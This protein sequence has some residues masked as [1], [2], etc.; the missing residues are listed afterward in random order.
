MAFEKIMRPGAVLG[1]SG[2]SQQLAPQQAHLFL[3]GH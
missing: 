1:R 3:K 2:A